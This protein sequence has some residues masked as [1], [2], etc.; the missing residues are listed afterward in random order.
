[1]AMVYDRELGH[2]IRIRVESTLT[3]KPIGAEVFIS[4]FELERMWCKQGLVR[5]RMLQCLNH[6]C[7]SLC[8][9]AIERG[10]LDE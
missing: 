2:R 3:D 6:L 9:D 10:N 7:D 5:S 4:A 1:M 8:A